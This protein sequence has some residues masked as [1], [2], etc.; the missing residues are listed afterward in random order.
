MQELQL[1]LDKEKKYGLA[2]SGGRDSMALLNLFYKARY[3]ICI[4]NVEHGIRQENSKRDSLFVENYAKERGI[5]FKSHAVKALDFAKKNK[6]SVE[7]AAHEL[8]YQIFEK[9]LNEG[10]CDYVVLGHHKNDQAETVLMH[11]LRGGNV[12]GLSGMRE[13]TGRYLRPLLKYTREEINQYVKDNNIPYVEDETNSDEKYT[14]NKV[15]KY[16]DK[17]V[18]Y[19]PNLVK[20]LVKLGNFAQ[21]MDELIKSSLGDIVVKKNRVHVLSD[22]DKAIVK[23]DIRRACEYFVKDIELE[24]IHYDLVLGLYSKEEGTTLD[25]PNNIKVMRGKEGYIIYIDGYTEKYKG[26]AKYERVT[27][28]ESKSFEKDGRYVDADKISSNAEFRYR[29]NGDIFIKTNGREVLLADHL[30]DIKVPREDRDN[31]IV[32]ASDNEILQVLGYGTSYKVKIDEKTKKI[33]RIEER[34]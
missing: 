1:K 31:I 32:L 22:R 19:E 30:S 25:F 4:I 12:K 6:I 8:R 34:N 3:N 33:F 9:H 27:V 15:R 26:L 21:E 29:R 23:A 10:I 11:M 2:I 24:T 7:A 16:I 28:E 18:E 14:R 13:V 5:E 17:A 20:S